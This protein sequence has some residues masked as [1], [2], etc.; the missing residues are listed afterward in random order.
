MKKP[1]Q[2]ASKLTIDR[3][4]VV[5]E[6][7]SALNELVA[8]YEAT[9]S[10]EW[11]AWDLGVIGNL[12]K[13]LRVDEA[14]ELVRIVRTPRALCRGCKSVWPAHSVTPESLC[15]WCSAEEL[16]NEEARETLRQRRKK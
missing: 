4:A 8:G 15:T 14:A 9:A 11:D 1:R 10:K 13:F 3:K 7:C 5:A 2:Q 12:S 6:I 16:L